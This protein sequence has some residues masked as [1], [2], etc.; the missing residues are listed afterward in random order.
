MTTYTGQEIRD[1]GYNPDTVSSQDGGVYSLDQFQGGGSANDYMSNSINSYMSMIEALPRY[2]EA[3]PFA[4]DEALA[5]EASTAEYAPYY[6]ELLSDY[7][8]DVEKT[9]SRSGSDLQDTLKQLQ[10][11][12]EYYTGQQRRAVDKAIKGSNEGYA[13]RGLYMSGARGQE[14]DRLEGEFQ[15]AY[16]PEGYQTGQYLANEKK[17]QTGYNR[18]IEDVNTAAQR[19]GRENKR[20]Q[21]YAIEGG[22]LDRKGEYITEYESGRKDYYQNQIPG[23]YYTGIYG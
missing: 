19:Y 23:G 5:R 18:G 2:D 4:F 20:A 14:A 1:L 9:K 6:A 15:K 21:D 16:G 22:V 12:R 13:G 7:T 11:G 8:S 10:A 17:A 3:N